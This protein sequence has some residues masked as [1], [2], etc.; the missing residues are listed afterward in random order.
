MTGV[1]IGVT[2]LDSLSVRKCGSSMRVGPGDCDCSAGELDEL[3]GVRICSCC[4]AAAGAAAAAGS[5]TCA[6]PLSKSSGGTAG[7]G[8]AASDRR[9]RDGCCRGLARGEGRGELGRDDM[10]SSARSGTVALRMNS[11]L[12]RLSER[13]LLMHCRDLHTSSEHSAVSAT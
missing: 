2:G 1:V 9:R 6:R 8:D 3:C 12:R 10:S 5:S 11:E 4:G 7:C 13:R